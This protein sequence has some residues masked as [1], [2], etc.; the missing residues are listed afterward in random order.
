MYE[1]LTIRFTE[2][3]FMVLEESSINKV[4]GTTL[5][6]WSFETSDGLSKFIKD[7]GNGIYSDSKTGGGS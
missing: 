6:M 4:S 1:S 5:R 2:N 3:G 7:W